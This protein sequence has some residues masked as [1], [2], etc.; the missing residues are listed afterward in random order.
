LS[1][2]IVRVGVLGRFG[3][4][5][6]DQ[7]V[8][9][10]RIQW[11]QIVV[12]VRVARVRALEE[13]SYVRPAVVVRVSEFVGRVCG[14]EV[15]PDLPTIGAATSVGVDLEGVGTCEELAQVVEAVAVG[16]R[17]GIGGIIGTPSNSRAREK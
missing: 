10:G 11:I 16:V 8:G 9:V 4:P 6:G 12:G 7:G 1:H 3:L 14:V 13:L 2:P 15:V 17:I 5:V